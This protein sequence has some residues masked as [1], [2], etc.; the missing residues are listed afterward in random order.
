MRF[1]QKIF[2]TLLSLVI[3]DFIG[4]L[5]KNA[6][7]VFGR[8]DIEE[9]GSSM[10]ISTSEKAFIHWEDFS[11]GKGEKVH[12]IQ[13]NEISSVVNQVVGG[14]A[15]H[16]LGR[17]SSTGKVYLV[18]PQGVLFSKEASVEVGS[19]VVSTLPFSV[20]SFVQGDPL[21][22][23]GRSEEGISHFGKIEAKE[24]DILF[25]ARKIESQG[26]LK[27]LQGSV[28]MGAGY[29]III[30]PSSNRILHIRP[31]V[32]AFKTKAKISCSSVIEAL[33]VE[34]QAERSAYHLAV[35]KDPDAY[36][37]V[38]KD[39]E[40]FLKSSEIEI[41]G[42][43]LSK[44][45]YLSA[46]EV[47]TFPS[48]SISVEE[49]VSLIEANRVF[50]HLGRLLVKQG[51]VKINTDC[52][53]GLFFQKGEV[54]LLGERAKLEY[55]FPF[56]Y[57]SGKS[58]VEASVAD[59]SFI[60]E[61]YIDTAGSFIQVTGKE[62]ACVSLLGKEGSSFFS[63]GKIGAFSPKGGE[64]FLRAEKMELA[65]AFVEAEKGSLFLGGTSA[66]DISCTHLFL[67]WATELDVGAKK[68]GNG[69]K[70]GLF[71]K[72][73]L[74]NGGTLL[75]KGGA[76]SGDA[77]SVELSSEQE[78]NHIGIIQVDAPSGKSGEI[79]FDPKNIL[80]TEEAKVRYPQF[81]IKEPTAQIGG[82]FGAGIYPLEEGNVVVTR[83]KVG[84]GAVYLF[85]G[86]T[87]QL[88]GATFGKGGGILANRI[89]GGGITVLSSQ[90]YIISSPDWFE[91]RGAA[92]LVDHK[93][94]HPKWG[95]KNYVCFENSITGDVSLQNQAVSSGGVWEVSP[96]VV[97]ISSPSWSEEKKEIGA[98]TP[99]F[100]SERQKGFSVSKENSIYGSHEK[101]RIGS[102]GIHILPNHNYLILSPHFHYG[103]IQ[104]AG[105]V[106]FV[107]KGERAF[108]ITEKNSLHGIQEMDQVGCGGVLSLNK[109]NYLVFS[110][111]WNQENNLRAGA[112]TLMNGEKGFDMRFF[113]Q[114]RG[115]AVSLNNSLCGSH[116]NDQVGSHGAKLL[117]NGNYVVV[118][119]FWKEG[120]G[121][122]TLLR[123]DSGKDFQWF[124][125]GAGIFVSEANSLS[126]ER[127]G[128]N[129]GK[130]GVFLFGKNHYAVASGDCS[131]NGIEKAGA[132]TLVNGK[133]GVSFLDGKEGP[134]M[135]VSSK[136]S[137]QGIS[138]RD[139][140]GKSLGKGAVVPLTEEKLL[141]LAPFWQEERGCAFLF[142]V[143]EKKIEWGG[144][145][146]PHLF[147]EKEFCFYGE[148]KGDRVG[149]FFLDLQNQNFVLL[150]PY[151]KE[152]R[153]AVTLFAK[154][155]GEPIL[156]KQEHIITASNSF[157]GKE[158][159]DF[160]GACGYALENHHFLVSSPGLK[161]AKKQGAIT[162]L[163]GE[164]GLCVKQGKNFPCFT[165]SLYGIRVD[166]FS[167]AL[168]NVLAFEKK[169]I[170]S[171]PF[172]QSDKGSKVS[173]ITLVDKLQG[174][175]GFIDETNSI[176]VQDESCFQRK[177]VLKKDGFN[178]SY[179]LGFPGENFSEGKVRVGITNPNC[180]T[181]TKGAEKT[182]SMT[183]QFIEGLLSTGA[184]ITL[185]ANNDI[186]L[187][188]PLK[189]L[190]K[191][192][193]SGEL[194][195]KAGR[196]IQIK[197][198]ISMGS[199]SLK[200][201]AN[202]P[203]CSGLVDPQRETGSAMISFFPKT[204]ISSEEGS[205]IFS[206][207][208]GQGK[209]FSES[210][211]LWLGEEVSIKT[212]TGNIHLLA[213]E[214][215]VFLKQGT[216]ISSQDGQI[217]LMGG[218]HIQAMEDAEIFTTGKG[219]ITL[220]VDQKEKRSPLQEKG[221]IDILN[222]KL[223]SKTAVRLFTSE[224]ALSTFPKTIN[225]AIYAPSLHGKNSSFEKWGAHYP[226]G[227]ASYPFTIFY[228]EGINAGN[229]VFL[230]LTPSGTKQSL[231]HL[232][233]RF[234]PFEK[235]LVEPFQ[236]W[237][238]QKQV[239]SRQTFGEDSNLEEKKQRQPEV[240][241]KSDF[242]L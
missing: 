158:K 49:R 145:V 235:V 20:E 90:D 110:P 102:G 196:S 31:K 128:D 36:S 108:A 180:I 50:T 237:G 34:L 229:E 224:R 11:L 75:A 190:Q 71:S 48:S 33:K 74:E 111:L 201:L 51:D 10:E 121:A 52:E 131:I 5:P 227:S 62:K 182:L 167:E 80:I 140:L 156:Q 138:P 32:E 209:T 15:S 164:S 152:A 115:T 232:I 203:L 211:I 56:L 104:Q 206:L 195:L 159:G 114:G 91:A 40:I 220:V 130:D 1:Y 176:F 43:I 85:N 238:K 28:S 170:L 7:P 240:I 16:I 63:S 207:Q 87:G 60:F 142:H 137:L 64:V 99:V 4:A 188:S 223:A 187:S 160:T 222:L 199:H 241:E 79:I 204:K 189:F 41:A 171:Q 103:E 192:K 135:R 132:I 78:L 221:R 82:E 45:F 184:C 73:F 139:Y 123:G 30:K 126:G 95:H 101:D 44:E 231:S 214:N 146:S 9:K 154:Q 216:S 107:S 166:Q 70:I 21:V 2:L 105:A 120:R 42:D 219:Q 194:V 218:M 147:P 86:F 175:N 198:S 59:I 26:E 3:Y 81:E 162:L 172:L 125:K 205:L 143:Q 14:K 23:R 191:G 96:E 242:S 153:G 54:L 215:T 133:N 58:S 217:L 109:G 127:P 98:L 161:V 84:E 67:N 77:G 134:G 94:G 210:G 213:E 148:D 39:G 141:I 178:G 112:V 116:F 165:N 17:I 93:T 27:A 173:V 179:L 239:F 76:L 122:V 97:L 144:K 183:P 25:L 13:P 37:L 18:N 19:L 89:G 174:V 6:T 197:E 69:G 46:D 181:F 66:K 12:F 24:G 106:T 185:Q 228:K 117:E 61:N 35:S 129:V 151:W 225:Q 234:F 29:E 88:V 8:A 136:N 202:E 157:I 100:L 119:P 53:E 186:I 68:E 92:T 168:E 72:G 57:H 236:K 230:F 193:S 83:S 177:V 163:N 169:V 113:S 150:S 212:K 208:S 65:G 38:E 22:C 118:S 226:E 200:V 124:S 47:T 155:T 55:D 233:N 149:S